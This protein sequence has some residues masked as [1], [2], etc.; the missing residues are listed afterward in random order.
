MDRVG[1]EFK[2]TVIDPT[3]ALNAMGGERL[4][5]DHV[6]PFD[7][8]DTLIAK[9]MLP[10]FKKLLDRRAEKKGRPTDK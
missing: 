7:E 6:H 2:L 9:M 1:A 4:F 5:R 10:I 3:P 8:G